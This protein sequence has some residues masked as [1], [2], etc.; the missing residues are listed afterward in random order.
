[1]KRLGAYTWKK[2]FRLLRSRLVKEAYAGLLRRPADTAGL[3]GYAQALAQSGD[4]AQVLSHLVESDEFKRLQTSSAAPATVRAIFRGVLGREPDEEALKAYEAEIAA[5]GSLES[6]LAAVGNSDESW[7]RSLGRHSDDLLLAIFHGLFGS[8]TGQALFSAHRTSLGALPDLSALLS[9]LRESGEVWQSVRA[10]EAESIVNGVYLALLGRLPEPEALSVYGREVA[11][12][13]GLVHVIAAIGASQEHWQ[14]SI[15]SHAERVVELAFRVLLEREPDAAALAHYSAN[16]RDSRDLGQLF[17]TLAGSQEYWELAQKRRADALVCGLYKTMAGREPDASLREELCRQFESSASI[18]QLIR[19]IASHPDHLRNMVGSHVDAV[20]ASVFEGMAGRPISEDALRR[21]RHE[22]GSSSDL[23]AITSTICGHA[24]VGQRID[25]SLRTGL[26]TEL[27]KSLLGRSPTADELQRDTPASTEAAD[28]GKLIEAVLSKAPGFHLPARQANVPGQGP[29]VARLEDCRGAETLVLMEGFHGRESLYVWSDAT[30]AL[31]AT[32]CERIFLSCNYLS[33]GDVRE[34]VV[35]VGTRT[36]TVILDDAFACYEIQLDPKRACCVQFKADGFVIP[37][38]SGFGADHRSLAFQLWFKSPPGNYVVNREAEVD[39]TSII[40]AFGSK[41]EADS[42]RPIFERLLA[43]GHTAKFLD[44]AGA[45]DFAR[46]NPFGR[47]S[48]L[49]A[50]AETYARLFN[51]GCAGPYIYA[52]HGVSPLKKYTYNPHYKRYDL[53]LLPGELWKGRIEKL[54]PSTRGKCRVVGYPK[55]TAEAGV[56]PERRVALCE[57]LGLNPAKKLVLFAPTWSGGNR[58]CGVFNIRHIDESDNVFTIPHD[59]D[60]RFSGELMAAG[61]R[62]YALQPGETISD[63]YGLA[64]LL[65]SDVSSTA[66]EFASLGKP[67]LCIAMERIPDFDRTFHED[68]ARLRVPHTDVY[69]DF[70]E[71]VGPESINAALQEALA[72]MNDSVGRARPAP[73]VGQMI[74]CRGTE[75]ADRCVDEIER[76]LTSSSPVMSA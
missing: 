21:L 51:E 58:N 7:G 42:L 41:K 76:F 31:L 28:V 33:Q 30:S 23:A 25:Q 75:A 18:E 39:R 11:K 55:L 32:G 66:I 27:Y 40:C 6:T 1:M 20:V 17:A 2:V 34:V 22:V 63:Y 70:C 62:I 60:V 15:A 49:V 73:S 26:V 68:A 69:W 45:V 43:R 72:V 3:D 24:V 36:E 67:T 44:A 50:A 74:A 10:A 59:G 53:T 57:K 14:Q 37:S 16:L 48:Y 19:E 64:D 5:S 9:T 47:K 8:S 46:T 13:D 52:E 54:Y 56:P 12:D 29:A 4:L 35:T 65:I 71:L 61:Y 38:D